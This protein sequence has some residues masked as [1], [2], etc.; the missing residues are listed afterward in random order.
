MRDVGIDTSGTMTVTAE[1]A[2]V[3]GSPPFRR[4]KPFKSSSPPFSVSTNSPFDNLTHEL[5]VE[6]LQ[7][8]PLKLIHL[9]KCV[10]K[11]WHDLISTP[12]FAQCYVQNFSSLVPHFALFYQH[13]DRAVKLISESPIFESRG[14]SLNFLPSSNPSSSSEQHE[15]EPICYLASSNGLV[16]CSAT[17]T[18][19]RV[20][21][22]CNPLTMHWVELPPPPTCQERVIIGFVCKSCCSFDDTTCTTSFRVVRIHQFEKPQY[23]NPPPRSAN[24]KLDIFS[25]DTWKWTESMISTRGR[26]FIMSY[27]CSNAV[28]CNEKLHWMFLYRGKIFAYDPFNN[29]DQF[30]IIR[31][32]KD[33]C[34]A[35][36]ERL[37]GECQGHLRFIHFYCSIINVWELKDYNVLE[38]SLVHN[39][40]LD[41]IKSDL[42][43]FCVSILPLHPTDGEIIYLYSEF[44]T[45]IILC[46]MRSRTLK[47]VCL[48][49]SFRSLWH[50]MAFPFV[51][52]WWP[53]SVPQ[54]QRKA[55]GTNGQGIQLSEPRT[56]IQAQED[57]VNPQLE[58]AAEEPS[59]PQLVDE[60]V[61]HEGDIT[62]NKLQIDED[63][64][65][66]KSP[67]GSQE[68]VSKETCQGQDKG[69]STQAQGK[70]SQTTS[71]LISSTATQS[72]SVMWRGISLTQELAAILEEVT[73]LH[74]ETF[75]CLEK[76]FLFFK[77]FVFESLGKII[78][79]LRQFR[80]RAVS[81]SEIQFIK[82]TMN[83]LK[84]AN[85]E[86]EWLEGQL[87]LAEMKMAKEQLAAGMERIRK[88]I[89][90]VEEVATRLKGE[91]ATMKENFDATRDV[92]ANLLGSG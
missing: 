68:V 65:T 66:N 41:K 85:I 81:A 80:C 40:N 82:S 22:V 83:D 25:S 62:S 7:R 57:S 89:A 58:A 90:E 59:Q 8:L 76:K 32:P 44:S 21:Y 54:F 15:P 53:T 43:T 88:D 46:N 14:F 48:F 12:Y 47:R 27:D 92:D 72:Q 26:S 4:H 74:P 2:V 91:Y 13:R 1:T 6:I 17:S 67:L 75:Q 73:L 30:R 10:S 29:T 20:Y 33:R 16:L 39:V 56:N 42:S 28:V 84:E 55:V 36:N 52:P 37:L 5:F 86:I 50:A 71:A 63:N 11:R 24:L 64:F 38:W 49:D 34:P 18:F 23:P 19:Q 51:L 3:V 61:I 77:Q 78:V 60:Q 79:I 9:C 69:T 35:A 31:Q 87:N 45:G 70:L